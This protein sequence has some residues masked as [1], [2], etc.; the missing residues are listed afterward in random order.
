MTRVGIGGGATGIAIDS[1]TNK[2]YLTDA[3]LH[4]VFSE[5]T[6]IDGATLAINTIDGAVSEGPTGPIAVNS[7]TNKV[8]ASQGFARPSIA[9]IDG[10]TL[11]ISTVMTGQATNFVTVDA[12]TNQVY[13]LTESSS[14]SQAATVTV[15]DGATNS[16]TTVGVGFSPTMAAVN[17]VTQRVYVTNSCGN[18]GNCNTAGTV[19]VIQEAH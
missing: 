8:Y 14:L 1:S 16:T 9:V 3:T 6:I 13:A 19:S 18:D 15:I 11:T 7:T 5:I 10:A 2:L 4:A 12:G 17:P